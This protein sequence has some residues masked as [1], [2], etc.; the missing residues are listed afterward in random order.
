MLVVVLQEME[1]KQI[2]HALIGKILEVPFM[3]RISKLIQ[4]QK[5]CK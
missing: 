2:T 1:L 4:G 3:T 5:L